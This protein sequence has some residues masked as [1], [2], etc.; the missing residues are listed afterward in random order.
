MPN[1]NLNI[2]LCSYVR[3]VVDLTLSPVILKKISVVSSDREKQISL[4]SCF[5]SPYAVH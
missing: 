5:I 1:V 3:M 4:L 2:F